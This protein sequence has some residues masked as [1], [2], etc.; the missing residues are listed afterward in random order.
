MQGSDPLPVQPGDHGAP[1]SER[2][3]PTVRPALTFHHSSA[4]SDLSGW[5]RRSL[6]R[7]SE[8]GSYQLRGSRRQARSR[9]KPLRLLEA[10]FI[11]AGLGQCRAPTAMSARAAN[12]PLA[13]AGLPRPRQPGLD[14]LPAGQ[15]E[16][17]PPAAD[18]RE[19]RERE[20]E[21]TWRPLVPHHPQLLQRAGFGLCNLVVSIRCDALP[22][23]ITP[24]V[25]KRSQV[26]AVSLAISLIFH[27]SLTANKKKN[28]NTAR[29]AA[30]Q[31]SYHRHLAG[32]QNG[33][34]STH[35]SPCPSLSNK[36]PVYLQVLGR[37]VACQ[38]P[39]SKIEE[40]LPR[41]RARARW[42][43]LLLRR[44]QE[45]F[46]AQALSA[47]LPT[48]V[49]LDAPRWQKHTPSAGNLLLLPGFGVSLLKA[50]ARGAP[51]PKG[52]AVLQG[53]SQRWMQRLWMLS[54]LILLLLPPS[55]GH[56]GPRQ[57]SAGSS[58]NSRE[59]AGAQLCSDT[60][61]PAVSSVG[62]LT[63]QILLPNPSLPAS[64]NPRSWGCSS[65]TSV[66]GQAGGLLSK[67][68]FSCF[69]APGV[70]IVFHPLLQGDSMLHM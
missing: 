6:K 66:V 24:A 57:A 9:G 11:S 26:D 65:P 16:F 61:M 56:R 38:Q 2:R 5:L 64:T 22:R 60:S 48:W 45:P 18:Q 7:R 3:P 31:P 68:S 55:A 53:L 67:F 12:I 44:G 28:I 14:R 69:P 8:E 36:P 25:G 52:R 27:P 50:E 29:V 43:S 42:C 49:C 54:I 23:L 70:E 41:G 35:R 21:H 30:P 37:S 33:V 51:G 15:D 40:P 46:L 1:A 4:G 20:G 17:P 34:Q 63:L 13:S 47:L 58:S 10:G 59:I 62:C 19:G 39:L 32:S